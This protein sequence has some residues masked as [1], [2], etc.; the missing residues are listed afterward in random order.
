MKSPV[1]CIQ[2]W[3]S[4]WLKLYRPIIITPNPLLSP[5]LSPHAKQPSLYFQTYNINHPKTTHYPYSTIP[6]HLGLR[7]MSPHS[8]LPILR[9]IRKH[10]HHIPSR[11]SPRSVQIT[12][13]VYCQLN[14]TSESIS[15]Y[16]YM[17]GLLCNRYAYYQSN[18]P[19]RNAEL[20][21]MFN[22]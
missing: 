6:N 2:A 4:L 21:V 19:N 14:K 7:C 17:H 11:T 1:N 22:S 18:S 12:V 13:L 8:S 5:Y 16:P 15:L 20:A 9:L 10:A 3:K